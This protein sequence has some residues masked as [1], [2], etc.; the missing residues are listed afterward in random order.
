MRGPD[1]APVARQAGTG[2]RVRT[3]GPTSGDGSTISTG[4]VVLSIALEA[5]QP[6]RPYAILFGGGSFAVQPYVT[7]HIGRTQWTDADVC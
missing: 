3:R 6:S 4:N 5:E 1:A 2:A 7:V